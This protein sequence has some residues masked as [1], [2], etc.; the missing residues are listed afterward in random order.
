MDFVLVFAALS[1]VLALI[2]RSRVSPSCFRTSRYRACSLNHSSAALY[3]LVILIFPPYSLHLH[4][5]FYNLHCIMVWLVLP[6]LFRRV[7]IEAVLCCGPVARA[8]CILFPLLV[9]VTITARP[10]TNL[11]SVCLIKHERN[12]RALECMSRDGPG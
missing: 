4:L 6:T 11:S 8:T 1:L 12:L 7:L 2:S 5:L 9:I 10:G 3:H